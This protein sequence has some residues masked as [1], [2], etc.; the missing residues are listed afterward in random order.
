MS[1][2]LYFLRSSEQKIVVDM[3]KYA[4]PN[5]SE[6]LAKYTEFYGFT[7]KDLGLYA[8]VD[9]EIAGAIWSRRLNPD[10]PP[11]LSVAILPKFKKQGVGIFMMEQF[12]QEAAALYEELSIDI[13]AKPKAMKF[14]EKFGFI[15]Q[16]DSLLLTKKL[17]KR[18]IVR[19]T[20]GYDPTHWMD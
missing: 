8:L 4:H 17:Q 14:Y 2:E 15:K 10:E 18:E 19:P 6:E 11:R 13:S 12:L 16:N 1:R 7:N 5:G 20:D 3:F 9:N